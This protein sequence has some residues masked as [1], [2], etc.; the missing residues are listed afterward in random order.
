MHQAARREAKQRLTG[1]FE[2]TG[3]PRWILHTIKAQ[4]LDAK[5]GFSLYVDSIGDRIRDEFQSAEAALAAGRVDFIDTDWLSVARC[6]SRGI[7]VTAV[8][9]YGRIVGGMVVPQDSPVQH[10]ADLRGRCVGV[11]R[12]HDKNWIITR[13]AC[14]RR[15]GFDPQA[16]AVVEEALSKTALLEMLERGQVDAALLY[17][18]LIP[19]LTATARYRE[20]YDVLDL[21]PDLGLGPIPTTFFAFR[22]AFVAQSPQVVRSFIAAFVEAVEL[23]RAR[24]DVWED[25]AVDL[26]PE[27]GRPVL[28]ALRDKWEGRITSVR[29][30]NTVDDLYRLFDTLHGLGGTE[31]VGCERI[32]EGTFAPTFLP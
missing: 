17:W 24:D 27:S 21:L 18:H 15:H 4:G 28:R 11:V 5:H 1:A 3:S 25:V 16:E 6:R 12:R 22:D 29:D 10:M 31:C 8:F 2:A 32:P 14:I 20:L 13:A 30:E 26:L 19:R 9:P 23:M 7:D